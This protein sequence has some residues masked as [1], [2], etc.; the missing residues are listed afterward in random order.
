M[1]EWPGAKPKTRF[2]SWVSQCPSPPLWAATLHTSSSVHMASIG[3]IH[4]TVD[5]R[6]WRLW[7][8]SATALP[9]PQMCNDGFQDLISL[10]RSQEPH[11]EDGHLLGTHVMCFNTTN[12]Y[13][14]KRKAL[15]PLANGG[16]CCIPL[17]NDEK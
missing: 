7:A 8:P 6:S 16:G 15:H 14:S 9:S 3:S 13:H 1:Q 11:P 17:A 10:V 2:F 5:S 4:G 12:I